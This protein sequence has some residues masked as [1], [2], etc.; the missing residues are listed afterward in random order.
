MDYYNFPFIKLCRIFQ[1]ESKIGDYGVS[2]EEWQSIKE[3][4]RESF[5]SDEEIALLEAYKLSARTGI[6]LNKSIAVIEY[7]LKR[8]PDDWED[9]FKEANLKYTGDAE[10][11]Q[12][13]LTK[14]IQKLKTKSEVM[15]ARAL[16][17]QKEIKEAQEKKESKPTTVKQAYEILASLNH[18]GFSFSELEKVTCGEQEAASEVLRKLNKK[19]G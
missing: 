19:N 16:K 6:E 4:F 12:E 2:K 3:S 5:Q 13:Y 9:Y 15:D 10:K 8:Q 1:D 17:L 18:A 14:Q 7:I 11:D